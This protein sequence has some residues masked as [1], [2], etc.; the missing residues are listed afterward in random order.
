[1]GLITLLVVLVI[2]GILLDLT[3]TYAPMAP[4]SN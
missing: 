3:E 4:P 2:V 1:M